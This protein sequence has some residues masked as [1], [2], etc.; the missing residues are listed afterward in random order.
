MTFS[1]LMSIY[2]KE[3]PEYLNQ[4]LES[5]AIQTFPA[6]EIVIVKDGLLGEELQNILSKWQDKL[7]LKIVGY[8]EN[9]GLAYALNYGLQ[10]CSHDL[11]ARMDSDDICMPNRFEKQIKYFS[12]NK[13]TVI[14]G[15]NILE[16]YENNTRYYIR[17]KNYPVVINNKTISLYKGSPVAHP[18]VVI[19]KEILEKYKYN[20]N[21]SS[22]ED[23]DLWFRLILDGYSIEN[24][25]EPLLKYRFTDKTF[26][27]RNYKKSFNEFIVYW[28]YLIKLFGFSIML[29][30]PLFRFIFRFLPAFCVKQ[31][32]FNRNN[33]FRKKIYFKEYNS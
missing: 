16:F 15:S 18:T 23:I 4:C 9:K 25:N 7:P 1:I 8:E 32:Y 31:I 6:T 10:F 13:Y 27:R 3:V 5:L 30:Y 29:I 26:Q 2:Y 19:K 21:V 24:I 20:I 33:F 17:E 12:E 11:I 28:K 14:L 22:N